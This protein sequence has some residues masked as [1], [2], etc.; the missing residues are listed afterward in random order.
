MTASDAAMTSATGPERR[1]WP[2]LRWADPWPGFV[3]I[4]W[5]VGFILVLW[6]LAI[7]LAI[8]FSPN[9]DS[10]ASTGLANYATFFNSRYFLGALG[11]TI[12]VAAAGTLGAVLL[13]VPLALLL[14][15]YQL[16]GGGAL[17][18]LIPLSMISPPFIGA[19]AWI[20]LLGRAGWINELLKPLGISLPGI[21]GASGI[22]FASSLQLYPLVFLLTYGALRRVDASLNEAAQSL[23]R[24]EA[25]V[26]MSVTLPLILPSVLTGALLVFLAILS[27]FAT[28]AILGE[29]FPVLATVAFATFR[30]EIGADPQMAAVTSVILVAFA[31]FIVLL[32]Q[33][34]A[35]RLS[36]T[37]DFVEPKR[38]RKL[39]LV[40]RTLLSA[41]AWCPVALANV[42]LLVVCYTSFL[43]SSGP[44]LKQQ[45]S[46]QSHLDALSREG[47]AVWNSLQYGMVALLIVTVLGGAFGFIFARWQS[48]AVKALNGLL[49]LPYIVPGTVI[50]IGFAFLFNRELKWLAGTALALIVAISVRRLPY[51]IRAC[52]AIVQQLDKS[53]EEAS[54]SLGVTPLMTF[55]K[56]VLPLMWPGVVAGAMLSWVEIL[57]ELSASVLLFNAQTVTL[58]VAIYQHVIGGAYGTAA[59]LA[60]LLS[61]ATLAAITILSRFGD[62]SFLGNRGDKS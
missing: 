4:G 55:V 47:T 30:S 25:H 35:A 17:R 62:I 26:F 21:Y 32:Q 29:N 44:V 50:G 18:I 27:D 10:S 38:P 22:I 59:A 37:H 36:F 49:M 51:M 23:G 58:P 42:P 52:C 61:L 39:P 20:M 34:I 24:S 8:S 11:N 1:S 14:S 13:A 43:A 46:L 40:R 57:S 16:A 60:A 5:L 48:P 19:Y 7:V 54:Q 53:L 3:V 56:V 33:A 28:A 31:L 15:G 2:A 6:P 9:A 41:L 45:F 12:T